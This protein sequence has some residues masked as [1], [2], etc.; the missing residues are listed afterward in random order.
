MT[1]S[2]FEAA[3]PWLGLLNTL[4][5]G[6]LAYRGT[7]KHAFNVGGTRIGRFDAPRA[8]WFVL[9][10][11]WAFPVMTLIVALSL[12]GFDMRFWL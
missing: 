7:R 1:T 6:I 8:Y 11:H 3:L 4:V 10:L 2:L 5:L 9:S 12:L